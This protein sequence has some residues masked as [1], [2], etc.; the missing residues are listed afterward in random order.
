[1]VRRFFSVTLGLISLALFLSAAIYCFGDAFRSL[2]ATARFSGGYQSGGSSSAVQYTTQG[3]LEGFRQQ[4][5][6]PAN[7]PNQRTANGGLGG[8]SSP[9]DL[10]GP[11]QTAQ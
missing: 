5:T 1:M 3:I 7:D 11:N 8:Y 9:T 4:T 2:A 6:A 10:P